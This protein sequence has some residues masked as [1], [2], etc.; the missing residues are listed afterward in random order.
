MPDSKPPRHIPRD[1]AFS[2]LSMPAVAHLLADG[3]RIVGGIARRYGEYALVLGGRVM[4]STES[5][6][7]AIAMLRHARVTLSSGPVPLS[8]D[9]APDLQLPAMEEA[10]SEGMELE[11]WLAALETER[12]ERADGRGATRQ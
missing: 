1:G 12:R 6:G 11:A 9:I 3:D 2:G 10:A 7:M 4:A 5:P 8:I